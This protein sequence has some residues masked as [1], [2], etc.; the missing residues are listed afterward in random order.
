LRREEK[1]RA[2]RQMENEN[3][4]KRMGRDKGRPTKKNSLQKSEV[5]T[6]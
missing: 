2:W 3:V 4:R 6:G 1:D 5:E